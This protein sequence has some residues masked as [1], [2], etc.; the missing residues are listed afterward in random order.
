LRKLTY[1]VACSI[2]GVIGSPSGDASS[3]FAFLDEEF[4]GYL[5]A[6]FPET[7]SAEGRRMLGLQGLESRR[8]DMVIQGRSSYR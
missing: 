1:F 8:F 7:I 5:K 2:D 4:L 3:M 6:E